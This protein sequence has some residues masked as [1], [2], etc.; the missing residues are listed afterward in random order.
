MQQKNLLTI[1]LK[2]NNLKSKRNNLL[3]ITDVDLIVK[4]ASE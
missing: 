4:K 1:F 3:N 2:K